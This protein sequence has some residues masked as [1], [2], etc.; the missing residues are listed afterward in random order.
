M[1]TTLSHLDG[2][3]QVSEPLANGRRQ[4][5]VTTMVD[6]A[7]GL[8]RHFETSY[9]LH[10][11]ELILQVKGVRWLCDEIARDESPSYV[12]HVL[13]WTILGHV[14]EAELVGKRILDF[15]CGAGA[16]TMILAR[17]FP[18]SHI[19]GV[20]MDPALLSIAAARL[21]YYGYDNVDLRRSRSGTELPELGMVD[22]IVLNGVYEHILPTERDVLIPSIWALLKPG[23]IVFIGETPQRWSPWE[24]HTTRLP[25]LNYL[26]PAIALHVAR[27]LSKRV[28]RN[29][30][31]E[32]L[33]RRGIRGATQGEIVASFRAAGNG[34]PFLLNPHRLELRDRFD[35]W[36]AVS[37]ANPPAA[38]KRCLKIVFRT[39]SLVG[40]TFVPYLAFAV[41]KESPTPK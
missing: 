19:T 33:L 35:L 22:F 12:Q 37:A 34:Q 6:F 36:Y 14:S 27:R 4:I 29:E 17:M 16:S 23:G 31:W 26:P 3:V 11:I 20:D 39:M 21:Q 18:E 10:L 9:P 2:E 38:L 13:T 30:S 28:R 7:H 24:F 32:E 8:R 25:F 41:K 1:V 5:T 40:V 15:G